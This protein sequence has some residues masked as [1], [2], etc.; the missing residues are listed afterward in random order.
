VRP[1]TCRNYHATNV[2]G[3]QQSF[4]DPE[5]L[6]IDPDFAPWVYQA[7]GAHVDAFSTAVRDAGYDVDAYEFNGALEAAL[8]DPAARARFESGAAPFIG[9][10][11]EEVPVEF[12]P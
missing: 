5:N 3:C 9:L 2:A 4:D 1:Q 6:D 12:S 11:G 8:S 7:G 10:S